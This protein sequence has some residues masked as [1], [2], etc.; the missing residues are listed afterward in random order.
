[1]QE[2]YHDGTEGEIKKT[3]TLEEL[4]PEIKKSLKKKNV[5]YVKLFIPSRKRK[6]K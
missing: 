1:M 2:V 4:L 6:K 3:D 5:A